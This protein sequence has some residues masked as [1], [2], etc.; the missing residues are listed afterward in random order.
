MLHSGSRGIGNA[1]GMY[2]IGLA[3]EDMLRLQANLPDRDLAYFPEGTPH[4]ADYV[5]AVD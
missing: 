1:I 2:F 3:R 5:E 4:F